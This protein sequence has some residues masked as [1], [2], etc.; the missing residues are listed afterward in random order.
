MA[1][2]KHA[3]APKSIVPV[4]KGVF[5]RRGLIAGAAAL[6][7]GVLAAR[8]SENIVD[9]ADGS[10][11]IIGP[12]TYTSATT[13]LTGA[14]ATVPGFRVVSQGAAIPDTTIDANQGFA[15]GA[16]NS[17]VHGRNDALNGIGTT[18]VATNGTGVYGQSSSG[19][20]IGGVSSGGAALYGISTGSGATPPNSTYGVYAKVAGTNVSVAINAVNNSTAANSHAL[21][22]LAD[23]GHGIVGSSNGSNTYAGLVGNAGPNGARA[24]AFYGDVVFSHDFFVLG[25]Q[26]V[27]GTKSAIVPNSRDG[28][29]RAVYCVEAPE[30]WLEDFGEGT[31]VNGKAD[32]KIDPDFAAV[33]DT[34]QMHI[35]VTEQD[36]S[37]NHLSVGNK[38]V[39]GF[40]VT[41]DGA[42]A[43]LKGKKTADLNGVFAWRIVMR[44]KDVK[45]N[46]LAKVGKPE[47]APPPNFGLFKEPPLPKHK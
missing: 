20:A 31:L 18:G 39:I 22:C 10:P 3:M 36:G 14:T 23:N 34:S 16:N 5:R 46:R 33:A 27:F 44:R 19:T 15:L 43:V 8:M 35:F 21:L 24:G 25:N 28:S 30:S 7:A 13:T 29:Y 9:A 42:I 2:Q 1:M 12:N 37:H 40:S 38:S 47:M 32:I 17:G 6:A 26:S 41:A 45:P 4:E 11:V